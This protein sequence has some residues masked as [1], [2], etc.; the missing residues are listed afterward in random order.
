MAIRTILP[1]EE[2]KM[3]NNLMRRGFSILLTLVLLFGMVS[4]LGVTAHADYE[5]GMECWYC[6]HYHWDEYCCGLCGACSEECTNGSCWLSTHC[7]ECGACDQLADDCT[8][9]LS[10]EDCYVNNGW[11][12]LGCNECHYTSEEELCGW[13]WFCADC[14]GGL[15]DSCGFCEGC[16]EVENIHCLECGNCYNSYAACAF[17]YDHCEECCIICEQCEECLFEDGIDLC[18]DCGLCVYC[19]L[20]NASSEGCSCGEYCVENPEWYEHVCPDCGTVY[21]EVEM[22]EDCELCLD[23][24][25]G[26]SDCVDSPP[27]CVE[28]GDYDFHFCED[29]GDCFHNSDVCSDCESAGTLLCESCCAIRREEEGCDCDDRCCSDHDLDTH[30]A[31]EHMGAAGGSHT[32]SAQSCWE[33]SDT[34]HWR[35]CRFCDSA[36]HY[37]N[38]AAHSYD[39]YGICTVCNYDSQKVIL[40]LKQPQ[41]VVAKVSDVHTAG[42]NDPLYPANNLRTFTV[43]AKGTS[44]LTYQWYVNYGGD[45]WFAM[46]DDDYTY[47]SGTKTNTLTL[48]VPSDGCSYNNAYKCVIT[49]E[50]GNQV[51]TNIAYLKVQHVY[52]KYAVSKG[53]L[54]DTI[55]QSG[56]GNNIGVYAS[57]GHYEMCVGEECE[58]EKLVPH[59]FSKQTRVIY[60]VKSGERWIERTCIHC[61][62]KSY[63]LDHIHYFYDPETFECQID[64]TYRNDTQHRL[65]CLWPGC[66]KTTLENHNEM[67]WEHL[68]TP[69]SNADKVGVPYKQCDICGYDTSKKLQT[70]SAVQDK[71]VD[72]KWDQSTDLVFVKYG[73]AS[74]DTVTNGTKL[75]IGFAPS[76][77]AKEELGLNYPTVTGWKVRYYCDRTPVG[78]V[79]DMD[80]TSYFTFTRVGDELKWS[81]TV[82]LFAGRTGGGILTFTPVVEECKHTE[83]FRLKNASE[84][85]CTKDGYTGDTVCAGCDGVIFYG[86]VIEAGT[87]HEGNLTLI[88]GTAR[89]GSCESRGYEG[90]YRCDHCDQKVRGKSTAKEHSGKTVLKNAVPVTCTEFGYSG[91]LY[92]EC[93]VLLKVGQILEPRHTDLRLINAVKANCQQKGY[94]GDWKCFTCNQIVKYGYNVAK[95]DHAWS[96]WGKVDDLYH[97]HTCVVNGCGAAEKSQHTDANRDLVCDGCGYSWAPNDH[98]IRNIVF[99]IDVPSIGAK[100]DYTKFSGAAFYSDGTGSREKNG[101]QWVDVTGN[102]TLVPGGANQVFQEGHVYKVII[103]FRA[104]A[105]YTFADEGVL[106]A[107]INGRKAEVEYVTYGQF[108]GISV[109]FEALQHKHT[110]TRIDKVSPTCTAPGKQTYYHC[111]ACDKYYEDAAGQ[112]QI[113]NL[114]AWGNL[115]ANGHKASKLCSNSEYHFKVCTVCNAEIAG[116]KAA[117][118]GGKATCVQKAICKDCGVAYGSLAAHD[119]DKN[120]W[121]LVDTAGHAHGCKT[122][123]CNYLETVQVHRAGTAASANAGTACQDCGYVITAAS[124]H[125]HAAQGGYQKDKNNHWKTCACGMVM[126]KEAH[127]AAAGKHTCATCGAVMT[128]CADNNKDHKCDTCGVAMGTHKAATG[129]HTCDY[130]GKTVSTCADGD[131]NGKCD[132]CGKEIGDCVDADRDHKCDKHN[133]DVGVHEAALGKHTCDYCGET[134]TECD[135]SNK[136][137][138]CDTCSVSMGVHMAAPGTHNC[139]YCGDPATE[140]DDSDKDHKCDICQDTVGVH[141]AAPGGH[142]CDYCNVPLTQCVDTDG[143]GKCDECT[144]EVGIYQPGATTGTTKPT[145]VPET[146]A[147]TTAPNSGAPADDNNGGSLWVIL[148]LVPVLGVGV[149]A[150]LW[151]VVWK[152][153]WSELVAAV[154]QL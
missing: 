107:T 108:A 111:T 41:S 8:E 64:T 104:T 14:M 97:R 132:V 3:R 27:M 46:K 37:S 22:C 151:F 91:D 11:H 133:E 150:I 51:T 36:S 85:I 112:K 52:R 48:S 12:C 138:E 131:N 126:K 77:Y 55:F 66:T 43:A 60:D 65:K 42:E 103:S 44:A 69:Y 49:D 45:K 115:A 30:I 95:T 145:G 119:I 26:N 74:C 40:I 67:G 19:C 76:E 58:A 154:K 62:F 137:H 13:C 142:V 106:T 57:E 113:T 122:E 7:S 92:C 59:S 17:D 90:T 34:H 21:C 47:T 135:D 63:I 1:K 128:Q 109:T 2:T 6:C 114:A 4:Q 16:W 93:G 25:E 71:M 110:M 10:C 70:Y 96:K 141:E 20:D 116:S 94:T 80:V 149:L 129:K 33:V 5:D 87:T 54:V 78:S 32:A 101:I 105:A 125:T 24:C 134:I 152:K 98:E 99:S 86:E 120:G 28:D 50:Q 144:E 143:D 88:E 127:K 68:G 147:P 153:T 102:K 84:P 79:V 53:A 83:G 61:D 136:D 9:C 148:V 75:V 140:C 123:G 146:T 15:C 139:D 81:L 130:C 82:P 39:K 124:N 89:E 117:H 118:S 38:K 35:P 18:D 100:P 56:T 73:Y 72:S 31:A 121:A 29:C 23:C